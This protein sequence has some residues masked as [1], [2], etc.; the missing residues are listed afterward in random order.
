MIM[1]EYGGMDINSSVLAI[2]IAE[3][4]AERDARARYP[5]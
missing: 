3:D 1:I 5:G 2:N 4:G